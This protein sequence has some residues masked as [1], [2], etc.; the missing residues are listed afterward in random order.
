M[1]CNLA[2]SQGISLPLRQICSLA[3]MAMKALLPENRIGRASH[4][5][6]CHVRDAG[7]ILLLPGGAAVQNVGH[8]EPS[9]TRNYKPREYPAARAKK[10]FAMQIDSL[11]FNPEN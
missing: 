6:F 7:N 11:Q 9:L 10:M 5:L 8:R 1:T 4:S 3:L 2:S